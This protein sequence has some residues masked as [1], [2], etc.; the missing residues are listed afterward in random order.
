MPVSTVTEY[1]AALPADRRDALNE[2][3]RGIN[4]ALPPGY[5]EGVQFGMEA[6]AGSVL[7][8]LRISFNPEDP[9]GTPHL[10]SVRLHTIEH[11]IDVSFVFAS[12]QSAD[13]CSVNFEA[14]GH[15]TD[16]QIVLP[17]EVC[18]PVKTW[19]VRG[20]VGRP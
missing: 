20:I 9:L 3:R 11:S 5:K 12:K 7:R 15:L 17:H 18:E 10:S 4:R 6:F 1:L 13:R 8:M 2:V 14:L 16:T 19:I